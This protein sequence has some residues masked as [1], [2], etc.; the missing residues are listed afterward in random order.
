MERRFVRVSEACRIFGC[1]RAT[2]YKRIKEDST[3]P[4]LL[5][6]FGEGTKSSAF[7]STDIERWMTRI[8]ERDEQADF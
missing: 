6:L 5:K 1:S 7:L 2:L 8:A 4:R 3:F